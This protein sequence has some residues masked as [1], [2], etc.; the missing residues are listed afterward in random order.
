MHQIFFDQQEDCNLPETNTV[1]KRNSYDTF[2]SSFEVSLL[3]QSFCGPNEKL[4]LLMSNVNKPS[5]LYLH[6]SSGWKHTLINFFFYL[7]LEIQ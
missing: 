2:S 6:N 7:L 3:L 1:H 4:A 5:S